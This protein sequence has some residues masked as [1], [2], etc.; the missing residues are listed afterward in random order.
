VTYRD[1]LHASSRSIACRNVE[2]E[3]EDRAVV[4]EFSVVICTYNRADRVRQ[5]ISSVLGQTFGDF[6]LVVVDDGSVDGTRTVVGNVDDPR[7]HYVY[8]ENGGLS[9]ARNTGVASSSGRYVTFLDDDD[10]ALPGWL[11]AFHQTLSSDDAV[12]T[13]AAYAVD[14]HGNVLSTIT[15][16]QLGPA[17][18]GYRGLFLPGTFSLPRAWYLEINGFAEGVQYCHHAEFALRLLPFCRESNVPVR[19]IETPLVRWEVRSS[20]ERPEASPEKVLTPQGTPGAIG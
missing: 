20:D 15:P 13:C 9:A 18:E 14:V 6:E 19:V 10:E 17:Y 11:E 1:P 8:R 5:A 12:A 4:T 7:L 3:A 16:A 2:R